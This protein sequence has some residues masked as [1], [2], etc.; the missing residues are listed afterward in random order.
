MVELLLYDKKVFY[1][2]G[3]NSA[4]FLFIEL[5]QQRKF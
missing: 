1:C 4:C 5:W 2:F 3:G